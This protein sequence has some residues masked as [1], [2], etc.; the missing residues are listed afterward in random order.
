MP[1]T[2]AEICALGMERLVLEG[3]AN[4]YGAAARLTAMPVPHLYLFN[5]V[6]QAENLA[7]ASA[8]QLR[9]AG[10]FVELDGSGTAFCKQFKRADRSGSA[11]AAVMGM[12]KLKPVSCVLS[13]CWPRARRVVWC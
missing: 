6:E 7:L 3:A 8:R 13:R 9:P 5:R 12:R 4:P 10:L 1:P 11:W 2:A